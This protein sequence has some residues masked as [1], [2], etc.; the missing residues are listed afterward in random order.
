[1]Q[2]VDNVEPS[3]PF[4]LAAV[5]RLKTSI[6][7]PNPLAG[8]Q[9][10]RCSAR[11]PP[12]FLVTSLPIERGRLLLEFSYSMAESLSLRGTLEGHAGWV[13]SITTPLDPN[14][15]IILSSSR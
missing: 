8:G 3:S 2:P 7:V 9:F 5:G 13:T 4:P 6:D 15:D 1:M 12:A 10:W 14:S 11:K